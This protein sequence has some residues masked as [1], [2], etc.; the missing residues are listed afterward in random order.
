MAAW[1]AHLAHTLVETQTCVDRAAPENR[2]RDAKIGSLPV[3]GTVAERT[4]KL[5]Y[6]YHILGEYY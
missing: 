4:S 1:M 6:F 3:R 5:C 2:I